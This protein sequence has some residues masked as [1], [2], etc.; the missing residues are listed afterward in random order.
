MCVDALEAQRAVDKY[1]DMYAAFQDTRECKLLK[2]RRMRWSYV[3]APH[4]Y[5][6]HVV[7]LQALLEAQ[8]EENVEAFTEAVGRGKS[9]I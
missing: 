6:L 1:C 7:F 4:C 5:I 8:E 3:T 2:V 9:Y